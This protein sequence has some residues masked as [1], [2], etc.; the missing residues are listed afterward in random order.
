VL[1]LLL[2][3]QDRKAKLEDPSPGLDLIE[4]ARTA[5]YEGR[6]EIGCAPQLFCGPTRAGTR[7]GNWVQNAAAF[8]DG[9]QEVHWLRLAIG[10]ERVQFDVLIG[11]I[12]AAAFALMT[13]TNTVG[14]VT[15]AAA[16]AS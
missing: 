9:N 6:D 1:P 16:H 4:I 12:S 15:N 7:F 8:V 14:T 3:L 11:A 5:L 13:L 2:R 10:V